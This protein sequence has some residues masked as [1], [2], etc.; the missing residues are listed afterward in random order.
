MPRNVEALM[1]FAR[2]ILTAALLSW[3]FCGTA[4]AQSI[5]DR[6]PLSFEVEHTHN[7]GGKCR[8]TLTVDKWRF[9]YD[10]VDK[11]EDSRTWK[12]TEV[13]EV[14]SKTPRQ[15]TLKTTESG[16]KTLG[17]GRNYKFNVLGRGIDPDVVAWMQDRVK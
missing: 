13:N 15:L 10:S 3:A 8:G 11:P 4:D 5:N 1:R 12:I 6:V 16:A 17:Q 2:T 9:T 7:G 14:E